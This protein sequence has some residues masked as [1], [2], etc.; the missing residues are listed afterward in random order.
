M[1]ALSHALTGAVIAS[2][3]TNPALGYAL[4]VI[5]HPLLD[6]IPH[7]DF[8][9]R[10]NGHRKVTTTLLLS[11]TDAVLGFTLGFFLFKSQVDPQ[12]LFTTMFLSQLPDWLES[13]Y[14]LL[15]WKFPPFIWVK[16]FQHFCHWKLAF[17]WGFIT[18]LA[19]LA[20]ILSI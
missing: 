1:L 3:T 15:N 2:K 19:Y 9:T 8:N 14:H 7:W 11:L 18:Q 4:A 10:C 20:L 13:P 17:P 12:V 6:L 5:S 16:R